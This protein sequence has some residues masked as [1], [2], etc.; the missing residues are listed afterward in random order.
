[1]C[2]LLQSL[3]NEVL[4][5]KEDP[6]KRFA[7]RRK[8]PHVTRQ[9]YGE[10]SA[11]KRYSVYMG[12]IDYESAFHLVHTEAVLKTLKDEEI[13][14]TYISLLYDI[15]KGC[16]GRMTLHN[17]TQIPDPKRSKT[18]R[19]HLAKAVHSMSGGNIQKA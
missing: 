17:Q 13:E 18:G 12:L 16:T 10:K 3:V 14:E 6:G 7:E 2:F 4:C 15:Y 1:M 9:F 11:C 8:S 19:Y 5:D